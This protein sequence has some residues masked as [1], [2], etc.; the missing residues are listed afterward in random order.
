MQLVCGLAGNRSRTSRG[1]S[2]AANVFVNRLARKKKRM[3]TLACLEQE[4]CLQEPAFTLIY[5]E[6]NLT[7][8]MSPG[9]KLSRGRRTILTAFLC[10]LQAALQIYVRAIASACYG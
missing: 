3:R 1:E 2:L 9:P 8:V 7:A 10:I 5:F 6:I 4:V